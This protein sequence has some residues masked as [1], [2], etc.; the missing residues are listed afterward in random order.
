MGEGPLMG[1]PLSL[2]S[3]FPF[4]PKEGELKSFLRKGGEGAVGEGGIK[5]QAKELLSH[6]QKE[7]KNSSIQKKGCSVGAAINK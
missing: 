3:L 7:E 5:S 1:Q 2:F 4:P 6:K